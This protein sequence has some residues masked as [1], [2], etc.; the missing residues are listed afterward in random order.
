MY[1]LGIKTAGHDTSAAIIKDGRIIAASG[2]DRFNRDKHTSAFPINSIKFCLDQAKI[3]INEVKEI[4]ISMRW[5]TRGFNRF[6][7][8]LNSEGPQSLPKAIRLVKEDYA[9]T[10]KANEILRKI[11]KYRGPIKCLDHHDCHAAAVYYTSPFKSAAVLSIDGAGEKICTGIYKGTDGQL[12][13]L[14]TFNFPNSLG[15]FY[16]LITSFLGFRIDWE[17]GKT[18]ALA[19]YGDDR[20]KETFKDILAV[21][22]H[23]YQ[24]NLKYFDFFKGKK[25]FFGSILSHEFGKKREPNGHI[26]NRHEAIAYGAQDILEKAIISLARE[27]K[28]LTGCK[29]ICICGGV[30]LN[31]I[32]NGKLVE[33]KIFDGFY[34]YPASGDDGAAIGAAMLPFYEGR[35][36]KRVFTENQSPYMGYATN[37]DEIIEA[38]KKTGLTYE[39]LEDPATKAAAFIAE[40]K[41]IAWFQGRNEF[42]PRALG[43]RSILADPRKISSAKK[44]NSSIKHRESF[45]PFA[46]SILIEHLSDYF[47]TYGAYSP[48]MLLAFTVKKNQQKKI[49]AVLNVDGSAR[50]QTV[51]QK[52]NPKYWF[53]INEFYKLTGVPVVLNTSFNRKGEVIVN[54]ADDAIESFLGCGLDYLFIENYLIM[55]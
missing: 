42:G 44:I 36:S 17:E 47:D 23:G 37:D 39:K 29:N 10:R 31:S 45:M 12:K 52:D 9:K 51:E 46:P 53:L 24:L 54:T 15:A 22:E 4:N 7:Y 41:I 8:I 6:L 30:A 33:S 13:R 14:A 43:N 27:S 20:Y 19:A 21:D 35:S 1:I 50:L 25:D 49:P 16:S 3:E 18:M 2:E 11:L 26:D 5:R 32:T 40:G 38:I 34:A 48:Y 28:R 55:K